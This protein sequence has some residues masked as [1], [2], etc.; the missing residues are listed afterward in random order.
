MRGHRDKT[1]VVV[2][3][4][5]VLE[6]LLEEA[7]SSRCSTGLRWLLLVRPWRKSVNVKGRLSGFE[8]RT[9]RI[10]SLIYVV[11]RTPPP[12]FDGLDCQRYKG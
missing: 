4:F 10:T 5:C 12:S 9:V 7:L 3:I 6:N 1:R 8:G 2:E 11:D